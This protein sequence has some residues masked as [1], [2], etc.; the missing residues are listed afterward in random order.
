MPVEYQGFVGIATARILVFVEPCSRE[1]IL[2]IFISHKFFAICLHNSD[3]LP[4][5]AS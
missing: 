2:K 5:F 4:T 1:S 3:I